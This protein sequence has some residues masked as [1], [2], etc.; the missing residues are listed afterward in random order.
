MVGTANGANNIFRVVYQ[1]HLEEKNLAYG[2]FG[3]TG[4]GNVVD[5]LPRTFIVSALTHSPDGTAT[6]AL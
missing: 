6:K 5:T 4:I 1:I 3:L 2:Y